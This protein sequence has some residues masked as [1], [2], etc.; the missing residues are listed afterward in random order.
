MV[1]LMGMKEAMES[2][3]KEKKMSESRRRLNFNGE[4]VL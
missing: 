4:N 3:D 1:P 2:F